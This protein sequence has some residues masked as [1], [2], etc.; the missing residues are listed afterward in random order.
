MQGTGS[1]ASLWRKKSFD[2]RAPAIIA[3]ILLTFAWSG[4]LVWTV[5]SFCFEHMM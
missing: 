2:W 1:I 4:F 5:I 3:S